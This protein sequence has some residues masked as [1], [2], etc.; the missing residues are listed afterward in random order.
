MQPEPTIYESIS[1]ILDYLDEHEM[2]DYVEQAMPAGHIYKDAIRVRRWLEE[3][4]RP[5]LTT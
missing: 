3:L 2:Q 5:K 4:Q 1:A